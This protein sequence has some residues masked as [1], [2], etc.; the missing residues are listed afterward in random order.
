VIKRH[1]YIKKEEILK[2]VKHWLD[3]AEK[4]E[5]AYTGLVNDHN[6]NWAN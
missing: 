3:L 5:A 2:E 6:Y 4:N 1:F